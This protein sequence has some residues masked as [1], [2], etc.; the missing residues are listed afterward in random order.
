MPVPGVMLVDVP[1]DSTVSPVLVGR[2]DEL[3]LL[4]EALARADEGQPQ[5]VLLG[6]EAGVGKSRLLEE[7]LCRARSAGA[8]TAVGG[9][10]ELGADG[11]PFAPFATALRSL[12]RSL[13]DAELASAA[14]GRQAE[15]ARLLPDLAPPPGTPE[16]A[17]AE[18]WDEEDGRA[19]LFELTAQL[20]ERLATGRTVVLVLEDLHWADRSTRE[21]L[22][23]LYRSVQT[24]RLL[25]LASYRADDIHRRHPLRP[26]LAEVDR[27]RTV[28]RIELPRLSRTEVHA[29]IAAI[30]G[31]SEPDPEQ[32]RIIFERSEGNPF[33]VEELT[34]NCATCGISDS[35][36]DLLLVR[37]EGLPEPVQRVLRTAAQA[38]SA[39]E[40]ALLAAVCGMPE[41]ELL[42]A[43]R[44]AVGANVLQPT[45]DGDGYRFRH[46]LLREA[47]S[48]D[49]LP[50]E[51]AALNR[52]YAEALEA[53]PGLVRAEQCT[54]RLA[55]HW[56]HGRDAS[57]ALP[58]VLA[59][60][61]EARRRHAFSEQHQLLERAVE[62]WH[63]VPPEV[64]EGLRPVDEAEVYPGCA[65]GPGSGSLTF[66]DVLAEAVVAARTGGDVERAYALTKR[67]LDL[68]DEGE[69]PL[70][71]AW[72]WVQRAK[73][74]EAS[75]RGDGWDEIARAQELVRGL[76]PSAVH[77]EVLASAAGW[78]MMH[79]PGAEAMGAAVRAVE[80]ARVVGAT[81]IEL[82]ARTTLGILTADSGDL[83]AGIA[84]MRRAREQAV[85]AG[86]FGVV[87][88]ADINIATE[89]EAMGRSSEAVAA[90]ARA[91]EVAVAHG[92]PAQCSVA[93]ICQAESLFALGD[94]AEAARLSDEAAATARS[95]DSRGW[96]AMLKAQFLM[97]RGEPV[98]AEAALGTAR[99]VMGSFAASPYIAV[100]LR[101][102]ALML[103]A[104]RD[105]PGAARAEL[106]AAL[107]RGFPPG[108]H[109]Y[110]WPLLHAAA[111][112]ESTVRGL[113][114]AE[115]GRS[116][117]LAA[118]ATA[119]RRLA[120]PAPV[121]QAYSLLV[122]AELGRA[123][124]RS[125]PAA[126]EAAVEAFAVQ[127]RPY[128]LAQARQRWAE[129]LLSVP[130]QGDE[131]VAARTGRAEARAD[132]DR[133]RELL[134]AAHAEAV[135]LGAGPLRREVE[136][137]AVRAR[138]P[139]QAGGPSAGDGVPARA[140]P[141]SA[142]P[143]AEPEPASRTGG[144]GGSPEGRGQAAEAFGLTR[145]EEDV[146]RLVAAGRSNRQIAEE[147][148]I[149]P[150]TASVHVSNI[151]AKLGV[152][153]RG[154]AAAMAHRLRL[155]SEDASPAAG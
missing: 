60:A 2:Q 84:E 54:T 99:E 1:V 96:A 139:L 123:H 146:L 63:E 51:G 95:V 5:A 24:S 61:V 94:W 134:A 151:L 101:H 138:L 105:E 58:V 104:E 91:V 129:S 52:R 149:S 131:G 4:R 142:G 153:G 22:G 130:A 121:W 83:D 89:L 102:G 137:L 42:E 70:R 133:A 55:H 14:C 109:R 76:A 78:G 23:Y 12:H 106:D 59:A 86:A 7:F 17:Q 135:R 136:Q 26:F 37:V 35:L 119:V 100:Q 25:V 145:R 150:K 6:G 34:A 143:A 71:A 3:G 108:T 64:R 15:L 38:G 28:R 43:L 152:A 79:R 111:V 132:R 118:L 75:G 11:L 87:G 107:E 40:H 48:E 50:G 49:L 73:L 81:T 125:D 122:R 66:M 82:Q 53:E 97:G 39:V 116:V 140:V 144:A 68:L 147:L 120:H 154:E 127:E 148:F 31:V 45:A 88:R 44:L 18:A 57:R 67:A 65:D 74:V 98:A 110:A 90:A 46:A 155:L 92:R 8:V 124:G 19:R 33:F 128:Q 30:Q 103:A 29:Q 16:A 36:R 56:Y 41:Q 21:L 47:V 27:L 10:L 62:L 112:H 72:F 93:L 20:L 77:A 141:V 117:T 115:E 126:W 85:E 9:C 32:A 69:E 114:A 13:G 113:P 80:L